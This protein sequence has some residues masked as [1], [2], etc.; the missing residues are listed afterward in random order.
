MIKDSDVDE[1]IKQ[2]VRNQNDID[3]DRYS[4]TGANGELYFGQ[5][6]IL[7]DRVALKFYYYNS[8]ISSHQEPLLLKEVKHDNILEIYDA[9]IISDQ[10]AYFL[11]PEINGGDLQKF[12]D[13]FI[14][15]TATAI[16]VTQGILKGLSELHKSPNDF[17]HRD[18]KPNNILIDEDTLQ[19]FIADFGS[20][21]KIPEASNSVV[22]SKSTFIYKPFESVVDGDYFKQS[23]IYQIGV[24]LFQLL[25]GVFPGA[26]ADWLTERQKNKLTKISGNFE[27]WQFIEECINQKIVKGKLLDLNSLP[28]FISKKLKGIIRTATHVDKSKRYETCAEFLKDLFDY[29][30]SAKDWWIDD[31]V[32]YANGKGKQ[33]FRIY[34]DKKGYILENRKNG[35][36]WRKDNK[37]SGKLKDIID[38]IQ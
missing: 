37:H 13:K 8:N 21:K 20:I 2:F 1:P 28:P 15:S 10:Y 18:L 31:S 23:D 33:E 3:I 34:R 11:T 4:N 7:K 6:K 25:G 22:A 30:K 14:I 36:S 17:V 26:A 27:Q 35:N 19:P 29:Q 9:R 32:F 24:V 38:K 16:S 5:R 12:Q